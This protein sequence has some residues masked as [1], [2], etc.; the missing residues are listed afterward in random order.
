MGDQPQSV[1]RVAQRIL[2]SPISLRRQT[3][4]AENSSVGAAPLWFARVRGLTLFFAWSLSDL[5]V[6]PARPSPPAHCSSRL[7]RVVRVRS[8]RNTSSHTDF[9]GRTTKYSY[10]TLNRLLSK[11]ADAFLVTNHLGAA[12]VT[13]T[14]NANSPAR[15]HVGRIGGDELHLSQPIV[16][17]LTDDNHGGAHRINTSRTG[18]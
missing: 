8:Q 17:S 11:T 18:C 10:D 7:G 9:K 2:G 16:T 3:C 14:Y 13:F 1:G 5:G 15:H 6:R 12:S 4:D